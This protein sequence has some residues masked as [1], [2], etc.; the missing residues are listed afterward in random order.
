M[1]HDKSSSQHN[2][3]YLM[4]GEETPR[5]ETPQESARDSQNR[6]SPVNR[7]CLQPKLIDNAFK[8]RLAEMNYI[9]NLR[10]KT[11]DEKV[12][13]V[14]CMNNTLK[15]QVGQMKVK[16]TTRN[17]ADEEKIRSLCEENRTLRTKIQVTFPL[18]LITSPL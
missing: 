8:R 2:S 17:R 18:K 9:Y 15:S 4:I 14:D 3:H 7:R 1:S 12:K 16:L 13:T 10:M 5:S 6:N 11:L